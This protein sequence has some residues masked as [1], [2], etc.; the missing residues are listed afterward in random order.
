[1]ASL[2]S[3][4]KMVT[5][6]TKESVPPAEDAKPLAWK[7]TYAKALVMPTMG[8]GQKEKTISQRRYNY[9]WYLMFPVR[10]NKDILPRR[11]FATLLSMIGQF[12]SSTVLNIWSKSDMSQGLMNGKDLPYLHNNLVVYCPHV[13]RI[14][15]LEMIWNLA[16][17]M[18]LEKM[19]ENRTFIT[20]L[21]VNSI[22]INVTMLRTTERE[23]WVWC[24]IY[25]P[26]QTC[27]DKA[28]T[29]LNMCLSTMG[30]CKLSQ[31]LVW[32]KKNDK[33]SNTTKYL[34]VIWGTEDMDDAIE[35]IIAFNDLSQEEKDLYPHTGHCFFVPFNPTGD[36]NQEQINSMM[37]A[38]DY[39]LENQKSVAVIGFENIKSYVTDPDVP[40][41]DKDG[42][43]EGVELPTIPVNIWMLH[44][45]VLDGGK[46]VA[47]VEKGPR[48]GH[49]FHMA[50][51]QVPELMEYINDLDHTI[52]T[53]FGYM[54]HYKITNRNPITK[55]F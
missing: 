10:E 29:E 7:K 49:Y 38:H 43:M 35:Q 18:A 37:E 47:S 19:K 30:S 55:K 48:G 8:N 26:N 53:H 41:M 4:P 13:K 5:S 11:K 22:F 32:A 15:R 34:V 9:R 28:K 40:L 17:E 45:H 23:L 44:K 31:Y 14:T 52:R 12:W 3:P 42:S 51:E 2:A 50:E 46:L 27:R 33:K 6:N 24:A 20:H 1:M 25:H 39:F 16:S 36:I 21:K 54:P